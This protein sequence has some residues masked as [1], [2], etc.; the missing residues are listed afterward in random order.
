MSTKICP[1][2]G[3]TY[4]VSVLECPICGFDFLGEEK[5]AKEKELVEREKTKREERI[6][7]RKSFFRF[8]KRHTRHIVLGYIILCIILV[9]FSLVNCLIR[10]HDQQIEQRVN[11]MKNCV[12]YYPIQNAVLPDRIKQIHPRTDTMN[13]RIYFL[14]QRIK[15]HS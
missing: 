7:K 10:S 8:W 15:T 6:K 12:S 9:S 5:K 1:H 11:Y 14:V 3:A 2:C 13:D 4:E